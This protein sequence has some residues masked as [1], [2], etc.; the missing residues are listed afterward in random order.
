M[1]KNVES[2]EVIEFFSD[3]KITVD[4]N[5]DIDTDENGIITNVD[6]K[7]NCLAEYMP[8]GI[9]Y[10]MNI[11]FIEKIYG[12]PDKIINR[13]YFYYDLQLGIQ[14]NGQNIQDIGVMSLTKIQEILNR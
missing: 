2:F 11:E 7:N 9:N 12:K 8:Y 5:L 1:D 10:M 4:K 3:N 14:F 13:T 6:F